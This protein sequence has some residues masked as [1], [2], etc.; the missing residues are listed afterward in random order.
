M[1]F[2]NALLQNGTLQGPV[3]KIIRRGHS[4]HIG[5]FSSDKNP[6]QIAYESDLEHDYLYCAEADFDV[7][8]I[9]GQPEVIFWDDAGIRRRHVPDFRLERYDGRQIIEVK[10]EDDANDP[11]IQ[12]RTEILERQL[13]AEGRSYLLQTERHIRVR[14]RLQN[15]KLLMN[16]RGQMPSNPLRADVLT[17]LAAGPTQIA[18]LIAAVQEGPH[19]VNAIYALVLAGDLKLVAPQTPLTPGSLVQIRRPALCP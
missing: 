11:E 15:A 9:H 7:A 8:E 10:Y 12:R 5:L 4:S 1:R 14:P 18:A 17:L 2:S 3:R 19:F 16:G 6:E 13:A